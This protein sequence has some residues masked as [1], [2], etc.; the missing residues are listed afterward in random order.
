MKIAVLDRYTSIP[1]DLSWDAFEKLGE[2]TL[3][4]RTKPEEVVERCSGC[5]VV[6][7]NKV[8]LNADIMD[9]LP[10]LK[11][12]GVLVT[13]TNMIDLEYAAEKRICVTNIPGVWYGLRDAA[14]FVVYASF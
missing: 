2:L 1:R 9:L 14:Y 8:V 12:I 13:G 6:F 7:S 4:D 10:N 3:H 11:Y 5:E